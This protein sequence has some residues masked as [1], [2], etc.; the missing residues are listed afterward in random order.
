MPLSIIGTYFKAV[1]HA[2]FI[3][4]ALLTSQNSELAFLKVAGLINLLFGAD[5]SRLNLSLK[6][7]DY[8]CEPMPRIFWLTRSN[9][10][11]TLRICDGLGLGR[12]SFIT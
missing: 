3:K 6:S 4:A 5:K 2:A 11:F 9:L 10:N 8:A 12:F 7:F 1:W